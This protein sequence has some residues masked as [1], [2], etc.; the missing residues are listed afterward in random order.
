MHDL[1]HKFGSLNSME[2]AGAKSKS[3][4]ALLKLLLSRYCRLWHAR[5]SIAIGS[6]TIVNETAAAYIQELPVEQLSHAG[7]QLEDLAVLAAKPPYLVYNESIND[8]SAAYEIFG[9]PLSGAVSWRVR[10]RAPWVL[11]GHH[12]G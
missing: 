7:T 4:H 5:N 3:V 6:E 10:R 2:C 12:R 8:L 9:L 11:V 1:Y